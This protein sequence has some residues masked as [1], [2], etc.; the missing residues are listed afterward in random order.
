MYIHL[1][2]ILNPWLVGGL[3]EI[4]C[5]KGLLATRSNGQTCWLLKTF[6]SCQVDIQKITFPAKNH[7][8]VT[9]ATAVWFVKEKKLHVIM[10]SSKYYTPILGNS[11]LILDTKSIAVLKWFALDLLG[12]CFLGDMLRILPMVNHHEFKKKHFGNIFGAFFQPLLKI[13]KQI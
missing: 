5:Q 2:L 4:H 12:F 1:V 9:E 7:V 10:G 11:N 6:T 8:P 13:F 3:L